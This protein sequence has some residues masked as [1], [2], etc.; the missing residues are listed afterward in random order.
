MLAAIADND[1]PS[2]DDLLIRCCHL[3]EEVLSLKVKIAWYEEQHRLSRLR[4]FG[5]SSEQTSPEQQALIFNEAE[6]VA[7]AEA[8]EETQAEETITYNRRKNKA[9]GLRADQLAGLPTET[10]EYTLPP[11]EQVCSCCSNPLHKMSEEV[12]QE[13]KVVP[14]QFS[15]LRHVRHVYS[16]RHCERHETKTPVVTAPMPPAAFPNSLASPSLVA[17]IMT[18]KFVEGLPL[19]RQEQSFARLGMDVSRQC[20]ANWMT[21]GADYLV[22]IC[23]RMRYHLLIRDILHADETTL[24]VL[25]EEGRRAQSKS[26]LWLYRSGRYGPPIVVYEYRETRAAEHPKRFLAPFHGYLHVDGYGAYDG[27]PHVSL[28]GCWAHAR[29]KFTEALEALPPSARKNPA[30]LALRGLAYC[31]KLFAI[32]RDLRE[33]SAEERYAQRHVRSVPV[34]DEIREW[35]TRSAELALPKGATAKAINYCRNQWPKLLGFLQDGRL[36]I[37][38]NRAERSIK[39]FVIGRKNWLFA[40][41]ASGAHASATI[42]S[43]VETAKENGLNPQAYLTYLFEQLPITDQADHTAV[44]KLL[45]FSPDL[46]EH[47]R[48]PARTPRRADDPADGE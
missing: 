29:R 1:L 34:L 39:P 27:L 24:Q 2:T 44:D 6:A 13:L 7:D 4:R 20:L 48:V 26:Y 47:V 3:E 25:H 40:N 31:N 33:M 36:E 8:A 38:N 16:C 21:K 11:E 14:A 18:A 42:Y 12:R 41:T 37:D 15:V 43:V 35:L 10:I 28:A 5:S 22:T 19:Y 17:A 30:N 23:D 45:A 9:K 46:P 32:E